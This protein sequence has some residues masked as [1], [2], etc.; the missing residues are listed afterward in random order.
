[1]S[2]GDS[3]GALVSR[4]TRKLGRSKP[5]LDVTGSGRQ[6][7]ALALGWRTAAAQPRVDSQAKGGSLCACTLGNWDSGFLALGNLETGSRTCGHGVRCSCFWVA[8]TP[9][10]PARLRQKWPRLAHTPRKLRCLVFQRWLMLQRQLT[11]PLSRQTRLQRL[12][13]RWL[14]FQ[15]PLL[16]PPVPPI[17]A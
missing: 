2:C 4:Q 9:K 11:V 17:R 5:G 12:L 7:A 3:R 10:W 1:M 6:H 8:A 13:Q 16:V 15:G 14:L